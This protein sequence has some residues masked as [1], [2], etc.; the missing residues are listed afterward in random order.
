MTTKEKKLYLQILEYFSEG[1]WGLSP[2]G[3][4]LTLKLE[5]DNADGKWKCIAIAKERV[6][7]KRIIFYS[8]VPFLAFEDKIEAIA[9]LINR[10]NY[11][12]EIGNFEINYMK[13]QVRC[14]TSI[15]L[16]EVEFTDD[17]MSNL[18]DENL[19]LT[20]KYLP[21]IDQVN[22]GELLPMDAIDDDDYD[23]YD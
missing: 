7:T 15:N 22:K 14:R 3:D 9:E 6:I 18:V 19:E 4:N 13:G 17:L 1:D 23:N 20:G 2:V 8:I 11:I 12:E 16:T 21:I 10:I 5:N